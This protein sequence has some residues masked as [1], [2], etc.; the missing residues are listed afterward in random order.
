MMNAG[1]DFYIITGGPGAGKTTL[2]HELKRRGYACVRE[3]A[4]EIIREQM[5]GGGCALPWGNVRDYTALM[6]E[7]S[8]NDYQA[9]LQT[10]TLCFFDR[11]IPDALGYARMSG[12]FLEQEWIEAGQ[13]FRYRETVFLLP[14][15]EEIYRLDAERKQDYAEAVD[16]Y[17]HLKQEYEDLGYR[18][19]EVPCLPVDLRANFVLQFISAC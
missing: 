5:T 11:G 6:L 1:S 4:R 18:I 7:R 16:T 3:A 9:A 14:P 2:L 12:L 15:W 17:R 8:V 10:G 19:V 13:L